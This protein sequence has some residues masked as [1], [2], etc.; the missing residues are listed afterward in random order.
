V[1]SESAADLAVRLQEVLLARGLTLVTA[2]S[3]TGGL[4]A[5]LLT[6]VSGSS[7]YFRGGIVAYSNEVKIALLDVA[8][9]QLEAH[10]AVSAQVARAMALGALRRL[11]SS[12]AVSVTGVA[13][14]GGGSPSKPVGLVYLAVADAMGVDVRRIVCD[15]DREANRRSA[16]RAAMEL[17]LERVEG[18]QAGGDDTAAQT[19]EGEAGSDRDRA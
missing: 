7:G 2:E 11:G 9:D 13:G 15:G 1:S 4:I 6:D 5:K 18:G 3:C 12:V 19:V 17:V 10:G 8:A 14:P 16:A